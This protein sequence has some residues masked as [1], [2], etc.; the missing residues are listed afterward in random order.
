MIIHPQ[1]AQR[2]TCLDTGAD[3]N[4]ISHRVVED[5]KLQTEEYEGAAVKPVGGSYQPE[6]QITLSWNVLNFPKTYTTTFAVFDE[7][8]STDFDILLGRFTIKKIGFFKKDTSVWFLPATEEDVPVSQV[9]T[10]PTI[11]HHHLD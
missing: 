4:V 9:I 8:H 5:L 10:T 7:R 2:V 11:D 3:L 1:N 6:R